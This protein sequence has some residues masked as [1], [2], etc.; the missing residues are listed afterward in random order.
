[1]GIVR[2]FSFKDDDDH[3]RYLNHLHSL[4]CKRNPPISDSRIL[5]QAIVEYVDHHTKLQQEKLEN[6]RSPLFEK[7][8]ALHKE[9]VEKNPY[10]IGTWLECLAAFDLL[11]QKGQEYSR[12]KGWLRRYDEEKIARL[13]IGR[14]ELQ[15]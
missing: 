11:D 3:R 10:K 2:S 8:D 15:H 14:N 6:F 9:W 5:F 7:L 4:A 13:S 12:E 1:M